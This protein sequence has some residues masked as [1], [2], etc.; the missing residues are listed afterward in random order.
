VPIDATTSGADHFT[1]GIAV[2]PS[3]S[4][5]SAR[6]GLTY[7]YNPN[8]ACSA[9][10]CQLDA[11]FISSVNGGASWSPAAQLAGP[12]T[13]SWLPNTSQGRMFGDYIYSQVGGVFWNVVV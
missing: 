1:P 3:T 9:S 4:G 7:Y 10:T 6:I 8:A 12:M 13:L 11:G 5:A 2:D